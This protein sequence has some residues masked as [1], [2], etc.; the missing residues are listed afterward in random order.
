MPE[1]DHAPLI[2]A[3][4][5]TFY[6]RCYARRPAR[7]AAIPSAE[8]DFVR[9]LAAANAS[10]EGWDKGWVVHQFGTNGQVFV[11]KGERERMAVPGAFISEAMVGMAPQLG[12][13]VSLRV[14]ARKPRSPARLLFRFRRDAWTNS[15]TS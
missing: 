1:G 2:Q 8:P 13:S 9:R 15:P 3:I 6:D 11:R 12:A 14:P 7:A 4:Q 5:A 10:R